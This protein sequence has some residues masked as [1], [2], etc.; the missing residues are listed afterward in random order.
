MLVIYNYFGIS[1]SRCRIT[2]FVYSEGKIFGTCENVRYFLKIIS[3][4]EEKALLFQKPRS[5]RA[6]FTF[7]I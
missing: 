7:G 3:K 1:V 2:N 4:N 5:C 6:L